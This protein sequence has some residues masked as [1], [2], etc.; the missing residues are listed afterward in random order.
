MSRIELYMITPEAT[1]Y[2]EECYS[3]NLPGTEGRFEVLEG[4][5]NLVSSIDEGV[6]EVRELDGRNVKRFNVSDG[7]VDVNPK[8]CTVLVERA[9]PIL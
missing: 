8:R 2:S 7:F 1:V 6:V 5:M 3:V 9:E 4:H